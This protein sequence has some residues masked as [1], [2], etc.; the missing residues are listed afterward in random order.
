M[1]I[2]LLARPLIKIVSKAIRPKQIGDIAGRVSNVLSPDDISQTTRVKDTVTA[3]VKKIYSDTEQPG[4]GRKKQVNV[5]AV[6]ISRT[7]DANPTITRVMFP[8]I[9]SVKKSTPR[10]THE[11]L[12]DITGPQVIRSGSTT[13]TQRGPK[14][15]TKL[16]TERQLEITPFNDPTGGPVV[17]MSRGFVYDVLPG[18][19]KWTTKKAPTQKEIFQ[20][21][22][23]FRESGLPGGY[24]LH[25]DEADRQ[26]GETLPTPLSF[27]FKSQTKTGY[28]AKTGFGSEMS[29]VMMDS[30]PNFS[31]TSTAA[32][33]KVAL[34]AGRSQTKGKLATQKYQDFFDVYKGKNT[35]VGRVKPRIKGK[36]VAERKITAGVESKPVGFTGSL[37]W[38]KIKGKKHKR[39][40]L[41][42]QGEMFGRTKG[43]RF[44]KKRTFKVPLP[45]ETDAVLGG[46][47]GGIPVA[48]LMTQDLSNVG[49]TFDA[50]MESLKR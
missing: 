1:V 16:R 23:E 41:W 28:G 29:D 9:F 26:V 43:K 31:I 12:D 38:K 42:L 6:K 44:E 35:A 21:K 47:Y 22:K 20:Q 11:F 3:G 8:G 13:T 32:K 4:G 30:Y 36:Y 37:T 15:Y 50:W 45:V 39:S 5:G 18:R 49:P 2:H 27:F 17:N 34:F 40:Q 46:M 10:S 24:A 33:K 19:V 48:G 25:F 7:R 14:V